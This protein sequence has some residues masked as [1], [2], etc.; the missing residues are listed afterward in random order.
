MWYDG[1][2]QKHVVRNDF[3]AT[4]EIHDAKQV[5]KT[6]RDYMV[7][8]PQRTLTTPIVIFQH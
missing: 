8:L 6:V 3:L 1:I 5:A 4:E 2:A 7:S